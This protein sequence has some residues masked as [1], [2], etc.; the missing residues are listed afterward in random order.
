[1]IRASVACAVALGVSFTFALPARADDPSW[2]MQLK[3]ESDLRFRLETKSAGGV[4][5]NTT[6]PRGV[7]RNQNLLRAK[8]SVSWENV[9][10]VAQT[11]LVLY[12][13]QAELQGIEAVSDI[14]ETQ[15]YR[16][17]VN[18]LYVEVKD[19]LFDGLTLRAGQQIVAWGVADQFNPTNLLNPDDLIDPLLFGKQLGN[20][21]VK[22]DYWV[23]DDFSL[24]A[25]LVPLFRPARIPTSAALGPA[26]VG[27]TPFTDRKLR[28]RTETERGAASR[29][30]GVPT[31]IDSIT[32]VNPEPT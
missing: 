26:Q 16:I 11:D 3:I 15:P 2:D 23:T 1:M 8:F 24:S 6:L 20:F 19:L 22:A 14:E 10:A 12:G 27:R 28:W 18:E 25:A 21:M 31:V 9:R 13:Y 29:F 32:V 5:Q 30:L 4:V 7:E 17:D